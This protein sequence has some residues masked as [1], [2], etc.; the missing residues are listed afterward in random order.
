MQFPYF[1]LDSSVKVAEKIHHD[2]GGSCTREQ[3]AAML[4]YNGTKN[5]GFLSRFGAAR[6]FGLVEEVSGMIRPTPLAAKIFA[7]IEPGDADRGKVSAFLNV[8]LF[9]KLYERYKGQPLPNQQGLENLL[10]N[11]FKVVKAQV[12]NSLRVFFESAE[13]AGFFHASGR[14]RLVLPIVANGHQKPSLNHAAQGE[15]DLSPAAAIVA[16]PS[17]TLSR[18]PEPS[19][20]PPAIFGLIRDLPVEGTKMSAP[21]RQRLIKAFEASINWLYPDE[22]EE[23]E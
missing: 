21:K 6:V 18:D 17:R 9:E 12:K 23:D 1:N 15:A 5:G 2:A 20:I 22:K 19:G 7:P 10:S 11:E 4:G 14:G 13:A 16:P 8:E 3:L